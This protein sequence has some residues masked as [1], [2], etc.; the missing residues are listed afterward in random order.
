MVLKLPSRQLR[1]SRGKSTCSYLLL[2]TYIP[3]LLLVTVIISIS[4][5]FW[6]SL[7]RNTELVIN[8]PT[9]T[10]EAIPHAAILYSYYE[11]DPMQADNFR[12][13]IRV[14]FLP[15][16]NLSRVFFG[17][18]VNGDMCSPC[19]EEPPLASLFAILEE[20]SPEVEHVTRPKSN[21]MLFR[22]KENRGM[23]FGAWQRMLGTLQK[24]RSLSRYCF[25][26]LLNS[27]TK[28]PFLPKY[29]PNLQWWM[30]YKIL[31][32]GNVHAVGSSLV[33]LP[34]EDLG[35]PGPRIESWA[36]ATTL[37]AIQLLIDNGVFAVR[38]EKYGR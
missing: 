16:Q 34:D 38:D 22:N 1:P 28:G 18:I 36:F 12:F 8:R 4:L 11:K 25:F 29:Y 33:C 13:F 26:V 2:L 3:S 19:H 32:K 27:S 30:T 9:S 20:E 15:Y 35:G 5:K 21:M 7:A 23:D 17:I 24:L 37:E 31:L 14:G 10:S 6:S